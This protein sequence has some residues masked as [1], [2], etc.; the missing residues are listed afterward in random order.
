M[1]SYETKAHQ[2][3]ALLELHEESHEFLAPVDFKLLNIPQYPIIIKNPMDLGTIKKNLKSHHY[4]SVQDFI[5]DIQLV[6]D[7]CKKFN[8][9]ST[10]LNI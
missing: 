4:A 5:E 2:L 6:W 10:V 8:E 1:E 3:L 7:N 9:V